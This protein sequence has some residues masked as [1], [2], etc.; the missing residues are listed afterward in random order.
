M[1]VLKVLSL[2]IWLLIVPFCMGLLML[3]LLKKEQRTNGT[4]LLAGYILEFTLL[5]VVGI[6]VVLLAVYNGFTT[7][8]K[9]YAPLSLLL[10]VAGS[11]RHRRNCSC[12]NEYR[13]RMGRVKEVSFYG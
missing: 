3:P 8:C 2:L 6:P 13:S 7:F 5:E 4:A 12:A 1:V 10:A 11:R 9:L